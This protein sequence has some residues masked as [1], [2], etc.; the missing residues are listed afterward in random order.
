MVQGARGVTC[1]PVEVAGWGV[2]VIEGNVNVYRGHVIDGVVPLES[3]AV[4]FVLPAVAWAV[5]ESKRRRQSKRGFP[6]I[7][8]EGKP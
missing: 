7:S 4:P 6:V 8:E 1:R 5:L 2:L 3:A